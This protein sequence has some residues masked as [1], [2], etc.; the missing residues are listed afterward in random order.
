ML[1][2][3]VGHEEHF[4][5]GASADVLFQCPVFKVQLLFGVADAGLATSKRVSRGLGEEV[6]SVLDP[7]VDAKIESAIL[8][9]IGADELALI[10]SLANL[11]LQW[12]NWRETEALNQ[13]VLSL[14]IYLCAGITRQ[15]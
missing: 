9:L 5:V 3:G 14:L 15:Q 8:V 2:V 6:E 1:Q 11:L 12:S 13:T 4:A 10:Q 7:K